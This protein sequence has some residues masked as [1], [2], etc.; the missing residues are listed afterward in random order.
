MSNSDWLELLFSVACAYPATP[1][2]APPADAKVCATVDVAAGWRPPASKGLLGELFRPPRMTWSRG[3]ARKAVQ[4]TLAQRCPALTAADFDWSAD[5]DAYVVIGAKLAGDDLLLQRHDS[6]QGVESGSGVTIR[7]Y[8]LQRCTTDE[9]GMDW[10]DSNLSGFVADRPAA[11]LLRAAFG[12]ERDPAAPGHGYASLLA[13]TD[14]TCGLADTPEWSE[15]SPRR[16]GAPGFELLA[17]P[18]AEQPWFPGRPGQQQRVWQALASGAAAADE[19]GARVFDGP[20]APR[21]LR[22]VGAAEIFGAPLR[23]RNGGF[24]VAVYDAGADRHRWS[25]FTRGCLNGTEIYWL[26]EGEG[27]VVGYALS[28]HPIYQESGRDGLFVLDLVS[29]RAYRLLLAGS[30]VVWELPGG[31]AADEDGGGG[32][33]SPKPDTIG[34]FRVNDHTLR[35]RCGEAVTMAA[36]RAAI[37]AGTIQTG[38]PGSV[39]PRVGASVCSIFQHYKRIRPWLR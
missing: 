15:P 33:T 39:T 19:P 3:A 30:H 29:A 1:G 12:P 8:D 20:G 35:T 26:A 37:T 5:P 24:A 21:V 10:G 38:S 23:G 25:F 4:T 11:G 28:G 6:G 16:A 14:R 32:W 27:L 31:E 18:H 2:P 17:L 7:R 36:I 34:R 22:K 9:L 13:G